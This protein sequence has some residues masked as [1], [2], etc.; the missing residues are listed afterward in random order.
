[1]LGNQPSLTLYCLPF[2]QRIWPGFIPGQYRAAIVTK[3]WQTPDMLKL[4]LRVS[5]R[6]RGFVPGQ[7]VLL[8]L[9]HNGRA[10]TRPFSICSASSLWQARQ[11]IELCC[12]ISAS[13]GFTPHLAQLPS[14]SLL[15]ISQAQ[16]DFCWQQPATEALFVAAGS[17]ITP[18]TSML[19]SQRHW[20]AGV[21][22]CYRFRGEENAALL[23]DLRQ[24]AQQQPLFKLLLSDSRL[25][26]AEHF[27][28]Q[29]CT[30]AAAKPLYLCGPQPFMTGLK[31]ALQLNGVAVSG[32]FQE[33]FGPAP[34]TQPSAT[35][36]N[37]YQI[38]V[39]SP[40]GNL[41]FSAAA[42]VSLLQSAEQQGLSPRFGCRIG[43]CFQCVCDKISGQ[44]RD[45]RT[46][47]LSGHGSEQI[48]LCV[49]QPVSELVLKQ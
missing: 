39:Q 36:D 15:S 43:V 1:M 7:H 26:T 21:T 44:V 14:G 12:K 31:Q 40:V 45:L 8:T 47:A 34:L 4:T 28:Q 30:L 49:S 16:G 48:Q 17:G 32:V 5:K 25:Q 2:L 10:L 24:L 9:Q 11:Q 13:G 33:Q 42:N 35:A 37:Q 41:A 46:G 6:W 23:K 38:T 3:A 29:I 20:L 19:L 18:L 22:L 27:Y